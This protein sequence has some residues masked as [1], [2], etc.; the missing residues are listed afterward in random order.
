[1]KNDKKMEKNVLNMVMLNDIGKSDI[2]KIDLNSIRRYL[3]LYM[4]ERK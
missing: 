2:M 1:M 4:D 3:K